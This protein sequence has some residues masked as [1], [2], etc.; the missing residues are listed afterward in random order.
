[1]TVKRPV[2]PTPAVLTEARE[3]AVGEMAT[4]A[5]TVTR[6]DG[7]LFVGLCGEASC[8]AV[9]VI[10]ASDD[11]RFSFT[12]RVTASNSVVGEGAVWQSQVRRAIPSTPETSLHGTKTVKH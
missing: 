6:E 8:S 3:L 1:M 4:V 11:N 2:S 9:G 7:W 5:L 10:G 12:S